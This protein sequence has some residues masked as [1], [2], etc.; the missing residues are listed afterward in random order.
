MKLSIYDRAKIDIA[1]DHIFYQQPRYV[2]HL[3]EPFRSRLTNLYSEYLCDHHVILD[4][5]SSW[6]SHLPSNIRYKKVIGHG[7]NEAE[8]ISNKRLDNFWV[9]NLNKT[10]NIPIEDSSID[11]GLIVAGWQYLQYPERVALELSRIIKS[12]SL[13]IISFTNRAFWTKAPNIWTYSSEQKRIE[14]VIS[15]LNANGWRVEKTFNEKTKVKKVFGFYSADSDP[16]F[17][18]IARNNKSNN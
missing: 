11:I 12:D 16:F 5:M 6:V 2:H 7:M 14:Y 13:L 10:Q 8:L 18:V 9:Q 17:S 1:D 4:L 3:S 15:V